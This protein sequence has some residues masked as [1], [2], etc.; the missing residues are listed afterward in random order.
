MTDLSP[1][2]QE[3]VHFLGS[4]GETCVSTCSV[5]E[6]PDDNSNCQPCESQCLEFNQDSEINVPENTSISSVIFT[7]NVT[8][9]RLF[10]RFLEYAITSGNDENQFSINASS[11][12]IYTVNMLDR[13]TTSIYLLTLVVA[14]VDKD[15]PSFISAT[16]TLTIVVSDVNDNIPVFTASEYSIQIDEDVEIGTTIQ[17]VKATDLDIG[18]NALIHYSI[19]DSNMFAVTS[20]GEVFT[21]DT[22]DYE[23]QQQ[24][25][26]I[27]EAM[28]AG[29][30]VLSSSVVFIVQLININ[31]EEP[32]FNQEQYAVSIS[33]QTIPGEFILTVEASDPDTP[34]NTDGLSF[35]LLGSQSFSID[36]TGTIFSLTELDFEQTDSYDLQV[37]VS[38]GVP[39][40]NPLGTSNVTVMITDEND[41][42]PVFPFPENIATIIVPE[43]TVINTT[44][45]NASATDED[46]GQNALLQYSI[47]MDNLNVFAISTK[48]LLTIKSALD[49]EFISSYN[50]LINVSDNGIPQLSSTLQVSVVVEDVNDNA[51]QFEES[52]ISI[53]ISESEPI[54]STILTLVAT[55]D[56]DGDNALLQYYLQSQLN[57]DLPFIVTKHSGVVAVSD[58]LDYETTTSYNVVATVNDTGNPSLSDRVVITINITDYNDNAPVFS[59]DTY[60][61]TIPENSP[62]GKEVIQLISSDP[63]SENN[64]YTDYSIQSG[65][66]DSAFF[67]NATS[68]WIYVN[69]LL[70]YELQSKYELL[71]IANNSYAEVPLT[72]ATHVVITLQDINEFEPMFS[73]DVYEASILEEQE[74]GYS[75]STILA[76][77]EDTGVAG[78]IMYSITPESGSF[79]ILN[80]GTLVTSVILDREVV[81][82]YILIITAV[83][84]ET[85]FYF[86]NTTV[87]VTVE[88]IND[89][90]PMFSSGVYSSFVPENSPS[91]T[92]LVLTPPL[93]VSD[94][95]SPGLNTLVTYSIT[96]SELFS[97]EPSTGNIIVTGLL[98]YEQFNM[99]QLTIMANDSGT[100]SQSS[101]AIINVLI[102]NINDNSPYV[103]NLES[104]ITFT[105]GVMLLTVAPEIRV[106]DEDNLPLQSLT[107]SLLDEKEMPSTLPDFLSFTDQV[108]L[109]SSLFLFSQNN[110][111]SLIVSG[112]LTPSTASDILRSL[113]FGNNQQEPSSN[114]RYL[115]IKL[116]DGIHTISS[117]LTEIKIE[118]INDNIPIISLDSDSTDGNYYTV[119]T[120]DGA[121]VLLTA[122]DVELTDLDDTQVSTFTL[123]ASLLIGPDSSDE[124]LL[125][126]SNIEGNYEVIL[127]SDNHTIII[128]GTN[129][130]STWEGILTS[131]YYYNIRN[132]PTDSPNRTIQFSVS[133]GVFVSSP[134]NASVNIQLVND[135]P[136]LDLGDNVDYEVIFFEGRNQ[137]LLTDVDN[138]HLS[139]SDD[140][141]LLN[142]SIVLQNPIDGENE[143]LVINSTKSID[144]NQTDHS[145][146][147][148]GPEDVNIFAALLSGIRYVN[149]KESPSS[150]LREILF[151]VSDGEQ[152][153]FATTYLSFYL[154]ND[155]PI[156]DLNGEEPGV[157]YSIVFIENS[158]PAKVFSS[159]LN[160]RD[161][162]S[163]F[164]HNATITIIPTPEDKSEG[165]SID[166][167]ISD[168]EISGSTSHIAITGVASL[169]EYENI[170]KNIFYFNDI[171]EPYVL[172]RTVVV[173]VSDGQLLN[174]KVS[175]SIVIQ[176]VNDIPIVNLGLM[177][178]VYEEESGSISLTRNSFIMDNDNDTIDALTV[179]LEGLVDGNLE[180]FE[181]TLLVDTIE[182][183]KTQN[184]D[185]MI[186]YTFKS[187]SSLLLKEFETLLATFQYR[188]LSSEP[189]PGIRTVS[190][191]ADDGLDVSNSE[192][193]VINITMIN[194]NAPVLNNGFLILQGSVAENVADVTILTVFATDA[195]S[196]TG[197]YAHHGQII[198]TITNGNEEGLLNLNPTNGILTLLQPL[199]RESTPLLPT[200]T[201]SASNPA[202]LEDGTQ[203]PIVLLIISV[204]DE[205]DVAPQWTDRPYV[206]AVTEHSP[207]GTVVG[208]VL[209]IDNDASSNADVVYSIIL[210]DDAFSIDSFTGNITVQN[211]FII[212]REVQNIFTITVQSSDNGDPKLYN[213]TTV[214]IQLLDIN[215]NAPIVTPFYEVY[216]SESVM[217]GYVVLNITAYDLDNGINGSLRYSLL[218]EFAFGINATTGQIFTT[219]DLDRE[220][221]D[222]YNITVFVSDQGMVSLSSSTSVLITIQD[223][224]DNPPVFSNSLYSY[225]LFENEPTGQIVVIVSAMDADLGNNSSILFSLE[226]N[227]SDYFSIDSRTGEILTIQELDREEQ[228]MYSFEVYALDQ[229]QPSLTSTGN[230]LI[231]VLD[232]NDN[233]PV[234]SEDPYT[235]SVSEDAV[236]PFNLLNISATDEDID[237]TNI[238]YS[239]ISSDFASLFNIHPNQGVLVL[240]QELDREENSEFVLLV[241]AS[242]NGNVPLSSV[243]EIII[244][245]TDVNDNS[246]EFETDIY[247]FTVLEN[248][249][250][251]L[252]GT[253]IASDEDTAANAAILYFL[254]ATDSIPF[255]VNATSGEMS[256]TVPLNREAVDN[257][258][259]IVVAQDGGFPPLNTSAIVNIS[260]SDSNDNPPQF[261]MDSYI[262]TLSEDF[263][264]SVP[265]ITVQANDSDVGVNAELVYSIHSGNEFNHFTIDPII[266]SLSL[267]SSL[268]AEILTL[269]I[270]NITA[271]DAGAISLTSSI[272]VYVQVTDVNDNTADI[273][274]SAS[275]EFIEEG[276][277]VSVFPDIY[278]IDDDIT[279]VIVNATV[280]ILNC[281]FLQC[282]KQSLLYNGNISKFP[283]ASLAISNDKTTFVFN[284]S[285]TLENITNILRNITYTNT[286]AELITDSQDIQLIVSD[287]LHISESIVTVIFLH[288]NDHAPVVDLDTSDGGTLLD[289]STVFIE[290]SDGSIIAPNPSI[291]DDDSGPSKL[292]SMTLTIMNPVDDP[293]EFLLGTPN[294]MVS[295]FPSTG[296]PTLMLLGPADIEYFVTV[297]SSIVYINLADDPTEFITRMISIT[298]DDG[299][300]ISIPSHVTVT[301]KAVNDPPMIFLSETI[302][303]SII[304]NEDN[305]PIYLANTVQISDPDSTT[306]KQLTITI[307][308]HQDEGYEYL[309]LPS[310]NLLNGFT[311]DYNQTSLT[312]SGSRSISNY[313]AVIEDIQYINNAS[314]PSFGERLVLVTISDGEQ[315]AVAY[316]SVDV[317]LH[318]DPPVVSIDPGSVVFVEDGSSVA[319]FDGDVQIID[320]DSLILTLLTIELTNPSDGDEE[321]IFLSGSLSLQVKGNTSHTISIRSD[322]SPEVFVSALSS[323]YYINTANE[324]SSNQRV[325]DV[326]VSDDGN[327]SSTP[328]HVL[329]ELQLFNDPPQVSLDSLGSI[330]SS[331]FYVE[332]SDAVSVVDSSAQISDEDSTTLSHIEVTLSP[333]LDSDLESVLYTNI[334]N[335][336]V[337]F[338][339]YDSSS[340]SILYN[341]S[342]LSPQSTNV[343]TQLLR[344]LKY[345]NLALEPNASSTRDITILAY[346]YNDYSIPVTIVINITLLND[347][348]PQFVQSNYEFSIVENSF[349][350]S[351]VGKIEAFDADIDDSFYYILLTE[352]V[353]FNIDQSSGVIITSE[354]LD[355]EEQSKYIL[356]VGLTTTHDPFSLFDVQTV[357]QIT[358]EDV[359][360]PPRFNETQYIITVSENS[361]FGTPLGYVLAEDF[362]DGVNGILNYST[363]SS[364]IGVDD[365]GLLLVIGDLDRENVSNFDIYLKAVDNGLQP[366]FA[367]VLIS[368]VITDVND[369]APTFSKSQYDIQLVES[370]PVSTI[371]F[372]TVAEDLDVGSNAELTFSL[373]NDFSLFA[374]NE[375]FGSI[376]TTQILPPGIY[377]ITI[378]A[379]DQGSPPLNTT[380]TLLITVFTI[381]E[382]LPRF[383]QP[384]YD[385][386]LAEN[387]SIGTY[388]TT[389]SAVDPLSNNTV[390][391]I[392]LS[393]VF[394]INST[395][396]EILTIGPLDRETQTLYDLQ[397]T[398]QSHDTKRE[399][400]AQLLVTITDINDHSPVFSHE[401]Y[402]FSVLEGSVS[403]HLVGQVLAVDSNDEGENAVINEYFVETVHFTIDINGTISVLSELDREQEQEYAFSVLAKDGGDPSLTGY[404]LVVVY[405]EDIND[406]SPTFTTDQITASALEN[407]LPPQFI[408]NISA[409]DADLG[410]NAE[411]V[412]STNSSEFSIDMNTGELYT[413]V[414][415]DYETISMYYL[416]VFVLDNG[417]PSLNASVSVIVSVTNIDDTP[418]VFNQSIYT[419]HIEEELPVSAFLI[420]VVAYDSDSSNDSIIYSILEEEQSIFFDIDSKTGDLYIAQHLDRE[421]MPQVSIT[422]A[423]KS[424]DF[425]GNFISSTSTVNIVLIDVNDNPPQFLNEPISFSISED[426]GNNVTV[427][428]LEVTDNDEGINSA[429][430]DFSILNEISIFAIDSQS[431]AITVINNV[432]IDRET[433]NV[434]SLTV[435]VHDLGNPQLNTST[436]VMIHIEDV[437][438]NPPLFESNYTVSVMESTK[439]GISILIINATDVD[440]GDNAIIQYTL[441]SMDELF[442]VN[443]TTGELS[444]SDSLDY[445]VQTNYELSVIASDEGFP[446]LSSSV[447]IQIMVIDNDD[448]PPFFQPS[449]YFASVIESSSI[450]S[451]FASVFAQDIDTVHV[452]PITYSI[453]DNDVPFSI[454][455]L[456]GQLTV[457]DSL[458]RELQDSY[459]LSIQA[460]GF[461]D[462]PATAT[463]TVEI[464]DVN[465]F[466]PRFNEDAYVFTV[467]ELAEIGSIIGEVYSFDNDLDE[468]GTIVKTFIQPSPLFE[469]DN[470]TQSIYLLSQLDYEQETNH[471][472]Y[473]FATDGGNPPLTGSVLVV[474]RVTDENDNAPTFITNLTTLYIPEDT[475]VDTVIT[476]I[477]SFDSDSGDN[478]FISYSIQSDLLL[479]NINETTGDIYTLDIIMLGVFSVTVTASDHGSLSQS[480]SLTFTIIVTDVNE[481]PSFTAD[482]FSTAVSES[483]LSGT[484]VT[485]IIAIDPDDGSNAILSYSLVPE[486]FFTINTTSGDVILINE[487]DRESQDRFNI[488]VFA[489]DG[490]SPSLTATVFLIIDVSD[491]NDNPPI[492]TQ[493]EYNVMVSEEDDS[494]GM[495]ILTIN[496]TDLD[497]GVNKDVTYSISFS[498]VSHF[499]TFIIDVSTGNI[500]V[501]S[502]LDR[503]QFNYIELTVKASDGG[504]PSLTGNATV[505]ITITDIDD[506][507]P[508]FS[509]PL[510]DIS[511]FENISI[512]EV[513]ITVHA[514]DKDIDNN[515]IINYR[516][517]TEIQLPFMIDTVS[518][519]V[520]VS[521]PGLDKEINSSYQL[522]IEAFNPISSLHNSTSI[523]NVTVLDVNDNNPVFVPSSVYFFEIFED[524]IVGDYVGTVQALDADTDDVEYSVEGDG[525]LFFTINSISG[526]IFTSKLLDYEEMSDISL[527]VIAT[528]NGTPSLSSNGTVAVN[529]LNINDVSP[530]ITINQSVFTFTEGLS[531]IVVG[532]GISI[533]DPD[534]L[535]I[536]SATV[537]LTLSDMSSPS[538]ED[539]ITVNTLSPFLTISSTEHII[540]I[541]GPA[542]ASIFSTA[543]QLIQFGSAAEEPGL[544]DRLL[545]VHVSDGLFESDEVVIY[546]QIKPVNDHQ[547][548]IDL[549]PDSQSRDVIVTYIE[550][551]MAPLLLIP[552]NTLISDEDI[553]NNIIS[554][555]TAILMNFPDGNLEVISA[556][557][558]DD[559]TAES[560][561][562]N[563][564]EFNGVTTQGNFLLALQT[565]SYRNNA[566]QPSNLS[567]V[568]EVK[569]TVNDGSF[570]SLPAFVFINIE[571]TNDPP[572]LLITNQVLNY[573]ETDSSVSV[574]DNFLLYDV[575][576]SSI[577]FI[578]LRIVQRAESELFTYSIIGNNITAQFSDDT[579]TLI[580]PADLEDFEATI[581][582][583][584]YTNSQI[585]MS[586]SGGFVGSKRIQITLNDGQDSSEVTEIIVTFYGINDPPIVD[587]NGNS[588]PGL[589]NAVTFYEESDAV[590][591]AD[592]ATIV[593]VDSDYL[594]GAVIKLIERPDDFNELLVLSVNSLF[595]NSE[596]NVT[597]GEMTI[598]GN[599]TILHYEELIRHIQYNNTHH[600]PTVATRTI[601]VTI[602]D[603]STVS[604]QVNVFVEIVGVN[605]PP[606]IAYTTMNTYFEEEGMA[607]KLFSSVQIID[608]DNE[609]LSTLQVI[610]TNPLDDNNE[611]ISGY[612][613]ETGLIIKQSSED[614]RKIFLFSYTPNSLGTLETFQNLL[615]MLT[616]LNTAPEPDNTTRLIEITLSDGKASSDVISIQLP[617]LLINDN[618]PVFSISDP[619]IISVP[620]NSEIGT[621]IYKAEAT[622]DDAHSTISYGLLEETA[623]FIINSTTGEIIVNGLIDR[624]T[625]PD[626]TL[627]VIADDT[628]FIAELEVSITVEDMNDNRPMF[629]EN[630]YEIEISENDTVGII[631]LQL[632]ATDRDTGP[633]A[634]I[635]Y[636]LLSH[637]T[638]FM[639]NK[640]TGDLIL[641][642]SLDYE[643]QNFYNITIIAR[644]LGSPDQLSSQI[645]VYVSVININD[646]PPS[647]IVDDTTITL[648]EDTPIEFLVTS[649]QAIDLDG[650][651]IV[652]SLTDDE[653]MFAINE[654]SGDIFLVDELDRE[655]RSNHTLLIEVSD[656]QSPVLSSTLV[657]IILVTDVDDNPPIFTQ[658][659]YTSEIFENSNISTSVLTLS[660]IDED[661]K[662]INTDVLF[663]ITSGNEVNSFSVDSA[664]IVYITGQ[665]DRELQSN[666]QLIIII[667]GLVTP[668]FMDNATVNITVLDQNDVSP[669]FEIDPL[670]FHIFENASNGTVVGILTASDGDEGSNAFIS[671]SS[672][673]TNETNLFLLSSDGELH[674]NGVLDLEVTGIPFSQLTVEAT[675]SGIPQLT[676]V[677][678]VYI[679]IEDVNE[680]SPAFVNT[681]NNFSLMENKP[682]G[683]I[684]ATIVAEDDDFS[685]HANTVHYS[686]HPDNNSLFEINQ[687]TGVFSALDTFDYE[688]NSTLYLITII[689][690]DNGSPP[691][692][693]T[694]NVILSIEDINEYNPTFS[695]D[696]YV[697]NVSENASIGSTILNVQATDTD[698]GVAGIILYRLTEYLPFNVTEE[699]DIVLINVLDR[700]LVNVYTFTVEA[701]NPFTNEPVEPS[702]TALVSIVITDVNDNP[703][704]FNISSF[705]TV[706]PSNTL[707]G[708][709]VFKLTTVDPDIGNNSVVK[710]SIH[711]YTELFV[712][713]E[714]EGTIITLSALP[715][716]IFTITVVAEDSGIPV[717]KTSATITITVVAPFSVSFSQQGPGFF[718]NDMTSTTTRM[719]LFVD[720]PQGSSGQVSAELAGFTTTDEF[721]VKYSSAASVEGKFNNCCL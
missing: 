700:E 380:V 520:N 82:T 252:I 426:V 592:Q 218:E 625:L 477:E 532:T 708:V 85:P 154:V 485:R 407:Q 392:L 314:E 541:T 620:E 111:R 8:D 146:I 191:T 367:E 243:V 490:G 181:Y 124:G 594:F 510:Y 383:T 521:S 27:I 608:V 564:V 623:P 64:S 721:T 325:V 376:Y 629:T 457:A 588:L 657:L 301:I 90:P 269:H 579:L 587:L 668:Q 638:E 315:S 103:L 583:I 216:V 720:E 437:N 136:R 346:D 96:K 460:R 192:Q 501:N 422:V 101:Q 222:T 217:I 701:F 207:V 229:G 248:V 44:I 480:T 424:A 626:Y 40:T 3:C 459:I 196:S 350:K 374:I 334:S 199:D 478:G 305:P 270:L 577:A 61:V 240:L 575:D 297:L 322:V 102:T 214:S 172:E 640:T 606:E 656:T 562:P 236:P 360:E 30:P 697:A 584:N 364:K 288:I 213:T 36:S 275:I 49:R 661:E 474:V 688:V 671:Y 664:G 467:S 307:T 263:P 143:R 388:V 413:A 475:P 609:I 665:I 489:K 14:D 215:D 233:P 438:D 497:I 639:L 533:I 605:D 200:L 26:L 164:L 31:D 228:E 678:T 427:G 538:T 250:E 100:P 159:N 714:I 317:V 649:I 333:V 145:I 404:A 257:Y 109:D 12:E 366:L 356:S 385:I 555:A 247:S 260:V 202:P 677:V 204:L 696:L 294:N 151:S 450:G 265:F 627:T 2:F 17:V 597:S 508:I 569:I 469:I 550:D 238:T 352:G 52:Y 479:L 632:N 277:D 429:I 506:N 578:T 345:E 703:P 681:E 582:S 116:F 281:S 283:G 613:N 42:S 679:Y 273:D 139:D 253:V 563:I 193:V 602:Q 68:G 395:T 685:I 652:F 205:N 676:G 282:E 194:D 586:L 129:T 355:R 79:S 572:V 560:I 654:T 504:V 655:T 211:S 58:T 452:L 381:E 607:V 316:I 140:T 178:L 419:I 711:N 244:T 683:T 704:I 529:I 442:F 476:T 249:L 675:D 377:N 153:S 515:S 435:L 349:D 313:I 412:Y 431:G 405:I 416:T 400:M 516:I 224:N 558:T 321:F 565:L 379:N 372:I 76:V 35:D 221:N 534:D 160:V 130:L 225:S 15:P 98:D 4:D 633:N 187:T 487:L 624:E 94:M 604:S 293:Q 92:P 621:V 461:P 637:T 185:G 448:T 163:E 691:L 539:F 319:L 18:N 709:S 351:I 13:E 492:F 152:I 332:E 209:A 554:N 150:T 512:G 147:I 62:I 81:D 287:G 470:T 119:F 518:G 542:K 548:I 373:L 503:E 693:S 455:V 494:I 631:L 666:Y 115:Q 354:T 647:F 710:Y 330:S 389:V 133:D 526:D 557:S 91:G 468:A 525:S 716:G 414:V 353:P 106:I 339:T 323:I 684:I 568:R 24:Y 573:T 491:Y 278:I 105:E 551:Q 348:Q 635:N 481:P 203:F 195:D 290:D 471:T 580:G 544:D 410:Q 134:V 117:N 231:F 423:A 335:N 643:H 658:S 168:L 174:D 19:P 585:N 295:I 524:S 34:N 264:L 363:V 689:A 197:P 93:S 66:S 276:S 158:S 258:E 302:N 428:S 630:V 511:V 50:I 22:L 45:L 650:F 298:A 280:Q 493:L 687:F 695:D 54:N 144:I 186:Y 226:D 171:K 406:N 57:E 546:V 699:G 698:G 148:S 141:V 5:S 223:S 456:T 443:S 574:F 425:N 241:E 445:E 614:N 570:S 378:I 646:N 342:F 86:T 387:S 1:L 519:M 417:E 60:V 157:N 673:D 78:N 126:T 63:D 189:T 628:I 84:T 210:S 466:V 365:T 440:I 482:I 645:Q 72:S 488:T 300:H 371:V 190:I 255:T 327:Q 531:P 486:I 719:A 83:N 292:N 641:Q 122:A 162:D 114:S 173:L 484:I 67:L 95:D 271:Q 409:I 285:F 359:N 104:T 120:E 552:A 598:T 502:P 177:Y 686:V 230:V 107:V 690:T 324:P 545:K 530:F 549:N 320:S 618:P 138:F 156:V 289:Y 176:L 180:V 296:G 458:D 517:L 46:S 242:D 338:S 617:V 622:D 341:L 131:I 318:N 462:P 347:N 326:I 421:S 279:A 361:P 343:Y 39:N 540:N 702:S 310:S 267:V 418:P 556:Q 567:T 547:P 667:K 420:K 634:V 344:S 123:T 590:S 184:G 33:E 47:D 434:F 38:D 337:L 715:E 303:S 692:S 70:D 369:N 7:T 600:E 121:P 256:N 311:M 596:Y 674:I 433:K 453:L 175:S 237:A 69:G 55:D 51:P 232:V 375:S 25:V 284:G 669:A 439:P 566:E 595:T 73:Q 239:I 408:V 166:S 576:S 299:N 23:Q 464:T 201:V 206:F 306:L 615:S 670:V 80:D 415:L 112:S 651:D 161:I 660:W 259:F 41:N 312:I 261:D 713:D 536:T 672:T 336:V 169:E 118:L 581:E 465:D 449:T 262:S 127:S 329:I 591:I 77:D 20:A 593:D 56:D 394:T 268:D 599:A 636:L 113:Q 386:S 142:A 446:S 87:I 498:N 513:V 454:N 403:G 65:N 611:E 473:I 340:S 707:V 220:T 399:S 553:G 309:L 535:V 89:N 706:V 522:I 441:S 10:E 97:I 694:I 227:V 254:V 559:V 543:L 717:L 43:D 398:A 393:D 198:Y 514:Q 110:D 212:D 653:D 99:S 272:L 165:L 11:G 125:I 188:H 612:N 397:V 571:P 132:E 495:T 21:I 500:I 246:P 402:N 28:D 616:Y 682:T 663:E 432:A 463:I 430:G 384:V 235:F 648:P 266:G 245:V 368:I 436:V 75:V 286:N 362:D 32:V 179:V 509:S 9:K 411:L 496:T 507:P 108:N 527:T 589:D 619:I 537:E 155:P 483:I 444:F 401:V 182:V 234:F 472:F 610:L 37:V 718:T 53:T 291:A 662:G 382:G 71:I 29:S 357:V 712:V 601:A 135:P 528:D 370:I 451:P 219:M 88:D 308:N 48:G 167:A 358:V 644:D 170:L 642:N 328:V 6:F 149:N 331:I 274:L 16:T 390:T 659:Y 561:S 59:Q 447:N 128:S 499:G 183:E 137:V 251:P 705:S 391:Y 505:L 208:N 304:Y 523:I 396:G 74:V 680:F 603:E